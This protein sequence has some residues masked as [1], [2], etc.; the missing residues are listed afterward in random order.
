[1]S[2]D[3]KESAVTDILG[4]Q[5]LLSR[6]W[7]SAKA[8][9]L[10]HSLLLTGPAGAGKF[11]VLERLAEGLLCENGPAEPCRSCSACRRVA[12]GSHPDILVVDALSHGFEE[13]TIHFVAHR[14]VR[15]QNAWAGESI[16]SFLRLVAGEGGWRV[17][18]I[19][20]ADRMNEETQNAFL[21]T[22]EEPGSKVLLA[23][24]TSRPEALL[25]TIHSR[26]VE[27]TVAG[28]TESQVARA[29]E[30]VAP[31]LARDPSWLRLAGGSPGRLLQLGNR[32]AKECLAL[33]A[34]AFRGPIHAPSLVAELM[35][36]PGEFKGRTPKAGERMRVRYLLELGLE[37]HRDQDRL[38][39]G[40]HPSKVMHEPVLGDCP[41]P[42]AAA[43]AQR[44][45]QWL[46]ARR[47]LELNLNPVGVLE[48]VL[49]F[50]SALMLQ[51]QRS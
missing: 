27:A 35:G 31:E 6:L 24:E 15:P 16:E 8:S 25:D 43:R 44:L 17:V 3:G 34:S 42:S 2:F 49:D 13:L 10:G 5:D 36:L 45:E 11:L 19:R 32:G 4:H 48:R 21:K 9:R 28:L 38:D 12:A 39:A 41:C 47:D 22:L 33:L 50:T 40:L 18:L 51:G 14:E 1:M 29:I 46:Q 26:L 37:L 23:L 7:G 20:D 30:G